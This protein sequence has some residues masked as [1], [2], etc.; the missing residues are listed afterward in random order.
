[1]HKA[2]NVIHGQIFGI[3]KK[4]NLAIF[5]HGQVG[6]ALLD[7][8]L[9]SVESIEKRKGIHLNIFALANSRKVLLNKSGISGN[10]K[11]EL[12]RA[13]EPYSV[14]D[15]VAYAQRHHL[16]NL[17]AVDNTASTSFVTSYS[18]L[19]QGGFDLV[20]SNKI[21]NTLSY[22]F[23]T[24]LRQQLK[25]NQKSYL[26]ETNVGAGLPLI[27][28]IKLLHL[29]G[30][31]ITGIKGVFSGSLSYIF[32]T[33]SQTD[34]PFSA[35]VTQA[36]ALGYTEP[37]PRE[38]LSGNDVGRK[39]LVLARELD[40]QN[41]FD[42]ISI[43]NLI[44]EDMRNLS[45]EEFTQALPKLDP[46]FQKLKDGLKPG[47]VLRYVGELKGDLQKNKGKL[48][49][50]LISI[51]SNSTLGQV[52]GSDSLIEIFMESYGTQPL[53][54]QGAG[55]GARVTARGVFG[56]ILRIAEKL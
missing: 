34:L 44:P 24:N 41:E 1:L 53:I 45:L 42:E 49:V 37:D 2:L 25:E 19:L 11:S 7:Q 36:K 33:L 27:D 38:D 47:Y 17:I 54:I 14:H 12:N 16:E 6:G 32:N 46:V 29:S 4:I 5:G 56:D 39:L 15:V 28:T 48:E 9:E 18:D 30:E 26:Y 21:A 20:S 31:N 3:N 40:L 55:A 13:G 23:Y 22:D 51:P 35:I 43:E 8:L 10:W 52:Q 50:K